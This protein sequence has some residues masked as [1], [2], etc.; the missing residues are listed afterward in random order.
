M[1]P[2]L[3]LLTQIPAP[4]HRLS[5]D[6]G[7][8]VREMEPGGGEFYH[9]RTGDGTGML[10]MWVPPRVGVV[11]GVFVNGNPGGG[12]G[13]DNRRFT[14]DRTFRAFAARHGFALMGLHSMSASRMR[15]TYAKA[16]T[17]ALRDFGAYGTH[18]ELGNLPMIT[19]GNSNGGMTAYELACALPERTVCF[20]SNVGTMREAPTKGALRVP[21]LAILG[22]NDPFFARENYR[23]LQTFEAA[24][25]QGA[26]WGL[27]LEANKGHE[28]GHTF[29][30][31][32]PY[33]ERCIAARLPALT[34]KDGDPR[35]GPVKLREL[36]LATG[37][38]VDALPGEGPAKTVPYAQFKGDP[39]R[40]SWVPDM[41]LASLLRG[42]ASYEGTNAVVLAN[43]GVIANP[44]D[45]GTFLT[46]VGGH[47]VDPGAEIVLE[48]PNARGAQIEFFQGATSLG[49]Q[50]LTANRRRLTVKAPATPGVVAYTALA[51]DESGAVIAA[52]AP[53]HAVVRDAKTGDTAYQEPRLGSQNRTVLPIA[54]ADPPAPAVPVAGTLAAHPLTPE[55]E[56][57]I[58]GS[59][60]PDPEFWGTVGE[61][62]R[63]TPANAAAGG[64]D[65]R[66][67]KD[68]E[69]S[70]RAA[71]GKAGLYLYFAVADDHWTTAPADHTLVE[72]D[73]LDV[74]LDGRSPAEIWRE[75]TGRSFA[76]A[77][78]SLSTT[79]IQIQ[80]P[81]QG[82][83]VR[84][85]A[86]DIFEW[87]AFV[88][89]YL[90]L[91]NLRGIRIRRA[92]VG[93]RFV[94]EWT[95]PW[96]QVGA[97]GLQGTPA[98][99]T[100]IGFGMGYNDADEPNV[101]SKQL[102]WNKTS[103]WRQSAAQGRNVTWGEIR[104]EG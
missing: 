96:S 69:V 88:L 41:D 86:A 50:P 33:F 10:T 103:P 102:R 67:E 39:G 71:W 66:D 94:Q 77:G 83:L 36:P 43:L 49:R 104:L 4:Q 5:T 100:R 61:Q 60:S 80:S 62:T 95:I 16:I 24:R 9:Y 54:K 8:V 11:R 56:A 68:A 65:F 99:G 13:G 15:S 78:W 25:R 46:E 14:R 85:S 35:K 23:I 34:A 19:L 12:Y 91:Q 31:T 38:L 63:M 87:R 52:L 81:T 45:R 92:R 75:P 101:P 53:A 47:V 29:D 30:L 51:Y 2:L 57:R 21:G 70:V 90:E 37:W 98:K 55:Q 27:A 84:Y 64:P 20:A 97:T 26:P 93:D 79:T 1:L 82:P 72:Y 73:A 42:L 76:N 6:G 40:T 89:P 28:V 59:E 17:G 3:P 44:E 7:D 58:G 32:M 22:P 18:P 74:L 48:A